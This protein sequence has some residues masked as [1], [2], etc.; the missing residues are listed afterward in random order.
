M[1]WLGE[2]GHD[3]GIDTVPLPG[4]GGLSLCGKHAIAPDVHAATARCGATTVVC[5]VQEGELWG[6]WPHYVQWLR[7]NDGAAAVWFPV[8]DLS[9]PPLA[10]ALP[11]IDDLLARIDR[12]EHLLMHCAAGI[13][14]TGTVAV[15]LLVARGMTLQQAADHVRAH[16]PMAGPEVGSQLD[17]VQAYA[18]MLHGA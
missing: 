9:A 17:L 14:R 6:H 8:P 12:G 7:D 1:D 10:E 4:S 5:L 15:C 3:G 13:G 16:R 11:L 2:R 18:A